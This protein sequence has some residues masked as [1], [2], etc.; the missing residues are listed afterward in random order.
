MDGGSKKRRRERVGLI[1]AV[2]GYQENNQEAEKRAQDAEGLDKNCRESMPP[3]V[4][5][6]EAFFVTNINDPF[7]PLGVNRTNASS[8]V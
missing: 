1:R 2:R 3:S 7:I 8:I 5:S 6:D 4:A